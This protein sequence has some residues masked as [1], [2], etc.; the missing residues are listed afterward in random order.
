MN[1]LFLKMIGSDEESALITRA[2]ITPEFRIVVFGRNNTTID[3]SMDLNGASRRALTIA[4]VLA[5]TEISGVEAPNVIDTPLGMMSGFVK[6]EVVKIASD[7]SAQLIL[8]LTHDEIKGC[9]DILDERAAQG[10]TMTNPAHY[11]K[12]L[13][14]DPG[15]KEAK[16]LLCDCDHRSSCALCDRYESSADAARGVA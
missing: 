9:E 11:P 5:L 1:E 4:F 2:E 6:T 15:T 3:P 8:F 7:N 12:I 14:N 16:V 13:K 10:S